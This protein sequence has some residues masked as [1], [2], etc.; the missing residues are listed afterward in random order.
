MRNISLGRGA[1]VICGNCC[2]GCGFWVLPFFFQT[3]KL[4]VYKNDEMTW[5]FTAQGLKIPQTSRSMCFEKIAH[6]LLK[7]NVHSIHVCVGVHVHYHSF[8][9]ALKWG[10]YSPPS[11][12]FH[13]LPNVHYAPCCTHPVLFTGTTCMLTNNLLRMHHVQTDRVSPSPPQFVFG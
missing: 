3:Q 6:T 2:N 12:F 7:T 5:D 8:G 1:F 10:T 11:P 4:N 9:A 13:P